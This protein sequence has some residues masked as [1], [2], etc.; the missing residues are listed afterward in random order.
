MDASL[1]VPALIF[2]V[3]LGAAWAS[4]SLQRGRHATVRRRLDDHAV[5]VAV[6]DAKR[7]D[8]VRLL[9]QQTY[10]SLP[11]LQALLSHVRIARTA[12]QELT[13]ANARLTV[14]QYLTVR[15]ATGAGSF[16]LVWF[17]IGSVWLALPAAI[18]GSMLPRAVLA[19]RIHRRRQAFEAQLA[20]AI[21][22]IVNALRAGYGFLQAIEAASR[23]LDGPIQEELARVVE[24]INLGANP[25]A[26]LA[27][28]TE[29]IDS[30]DFALVAT[31]VS[32][33]RTIGGNLAEVLENIAATVRERHRIRGEVRA[34]TTG[35]RV[36]SYVLGLIPL[37]LLVWF[38]S[39]NASYRGVMFHSSAGKAMIVFAT[40]WS[41]IGLFTSRK[42]AVAEY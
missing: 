24:E 10:S 37:G 6:E 26:A 1:L 3:V 14:P 11:I 42:V 28:I 2:V 21:D 5:P 31:A 13:R 12:D 7:L 38:S 9:K 18:V 29:R 25:A 19:L 39:T 41:L 40:V 30:Y 20:E 34:L 35:P 27:A 23:D 36:S 22:L 33:Q 32:V 16:L 17:A 8:R 15:L 4:S